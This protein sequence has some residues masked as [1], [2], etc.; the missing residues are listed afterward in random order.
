MARK[1]W[2][3]DAA[4]ILLGQLCRHPV[5]PP[6]KA[7]RQPCHDLRPGVAAPE[8][9]LRRTVDG[10]RRPLLVF[11]LQFVVRHRGRTAL[12]HPDFQGER[13][14]RHCR[15]RDQPPQKRVELGGLPTRDLQGRHLST[16]VH[17]HRAQRRRR[18]DTRLGQPER[19]LAL[20]QQR[21][22]R[23]MERHARPRPQEPER[24]DQ[25]ESLSEN[26][27]RRL[28]LCRLPLRHGERLQRSLHQCLQPV[29]QPH[30]Q[31]GRVLGRHADH[32]QLDRRYGQDA[33][34]V[35]QAAADDG[36]RPCRR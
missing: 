25:R 31:R 26:A 15:H 4:G 13:H 33:H 20:I 22:G 3:R 35:C 27:A 32:P 34:A 7:G 2:R 6:R 29:C 21:H 19:L 11:Q 30:L 5:E 14:R 16:A 18:Q 23:G 36:P 12:A 8:R 24:A 1:L 28:W 17:R 9:Q 10:I